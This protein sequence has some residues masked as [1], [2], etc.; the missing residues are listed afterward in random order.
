MPGTPW[1]CRCCLHVE[2]MPHDMHSDTNS[3]CDKQC[4][5]LDL[6]LPSPWFLPLYSY[7]CLSAYMN[8]SAAPCV[9]LLPC[10]GGGYGGAAL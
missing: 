6:Y 1:T 5:S 2:S 3:N 9:G 10:A 4:R 8:M 7:V